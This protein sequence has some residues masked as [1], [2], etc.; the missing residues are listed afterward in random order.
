METK[1]YLAFDFG[2]SSGRAMLCSLENGKMK[3]DEIHRFSNDPVSVC[4]HLYWDVLRLFH[5]IKQGILKANAAGGFDFIG[6]DTWGVDF[7]LL[8]KNGEMTA[9]PVHYRDV[10]TEGMQEALS[11]D[12]SKEDLYKCNGT[13]QIDLNTVY[14]LK[15][16]S[17]KRPETLKQAK[18]LLLIPDMFA[19]MLTGEERTEYTNA[20]TTGLLDPKTKKWNT[21]ILNA[22][23]VD[24]DIFGKMIFPGETYG[25]LREDICEELHC[26]KVP[27]IAVATH[28]TGSAVVAVPTTE[29]DYAYISCGTWSLL[30]TVTDE[31]ILSDVSLSK[32]FTNEGAFDGKIR[33]LK[34]I[35]GLWLIQQSR[36]EFKR[37]GLD[38]SF[39]EMEKSARE[40]APFACFIDPDAKDFVA[41]G[42]MPKRVQEYCRKTGQYVP[43]D[44]GEILRC[45]YQSLAFKYRYTVNKMEELTGKKFPAI[46]MIGGGIK[47]GLLCSMTAD[48]CRKPVFAGPVE[49]TVIGNATVLM[50]SAGEIE[51]ITKGREIIKNSFEIK[52]YTPNGSDSFDAEY[53]KFKSALKLQ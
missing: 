7:A 3:I 44:M 24:E 2:A 34:N 31:P 16:L 50:M 10:R 46:H 53:E 51:N 30:G 21:R 15:Y 39:D 43:R 5:E 6:I 1:K 49:A 26:K 45:I 14:Q 23:G 19:Y 12:I 4:G 22:V 36:H 42:D 18:R 48:Y 25:E 20:S 47:D 29:K 38:V 32:G 40:A 9:N 37:R 28:D 27:V 41:P 35:M 11:L 33:Y 52:E 13:Q 8:D 17:L